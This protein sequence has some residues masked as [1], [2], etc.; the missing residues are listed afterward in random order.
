MTV[1]SSSASAVF[2]VV[3]VIVA[4][5][6]VTAVAVA[7]SNDEVAATNLTVE[8]TEPPSAT[9]TGVGLTDAETDGI[10]FMREEE[11]LAR[12]VYLGLADPWDLRVF[13]NIAAMGR[14]RLNHGTP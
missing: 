6:G 5:I 9:T 13:E 11:K 12:D 8:P 10:L 7:A 2:L 14:T 4:V 1:K 3:A